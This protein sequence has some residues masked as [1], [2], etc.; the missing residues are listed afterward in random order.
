MEKQIENIEKKIHKF[1]INSDIY[2][3]L[4]KKKMNLSN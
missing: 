4:T 3:Y 1:I 2:E